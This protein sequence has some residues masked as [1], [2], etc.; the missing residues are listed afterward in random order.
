VLAVAT[1][2]EVVEGGETPARSAG[3]G[4]SGGRPPH[5][6]RGRSTAYVERHIVGVFVTPAVLFIVVMM[7]F[8]VGY[9]LWLSLHE[10]TGGLTTAPR[11]V[12]LDNFARLFFDDPRFWGAVRRTFAFTGMAIVTQTV[13]GVAIAVMLNREFRARGLVRTVFLLPMIATPVAVAL[14]WRL[15]YQPQLGILNDLLTSLGLPPSG[16]VS[17]PS[18][19]LVALAVVDVWE[20]TPLITLITLAG[21]TALPE[22]PFEAAVVD[23]ANGWQTFWYVTLPMVRP[24]IVVAVVFRLIEA[25]KTFDSILVITQGGPGFAT[26]TLNIYVYQTSFQYQRLGY[27]AALLIVFFFIVLG[28]AGLLLR[29]RRASDDR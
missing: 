9:T 24:V 25:L 19:A 2:D 3:P 1:T 4:A 17:D 8:P 21:L 28:S 26:E 29:F 20:W 22:D 18:L 16:W 14:V 11:F 6:S 15:M 27:A 13:L 7:A 5:G 12:G 23:G 10:W